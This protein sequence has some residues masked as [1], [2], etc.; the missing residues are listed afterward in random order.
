MSSH[1]PNPEIA[2][3]IQAALSVV[4]PIVSAYTYPLF[5]ADDR[6]RP[7]L[8][9]SSILLE[10]DGR[11]VLLTAAHAIHEISQAGSAVHLGAT[12]ITHLTSTFTRTSVDGQDPLDLAATLISEEFRQEQLMQALPMHRT[13]GSD[14]LS[15]PHMRCVHGY[16]ITK[17]KTTKRADETR[18]VFTRYGLTYAGA[19]HDLDVDFARHKKRNDTHLVMKYQ[20]ESRDDTGGQITPPHPKGI[21]GGGMWSIPDSFSPGIVFLEGI[22][23]EFRDSSLVFA[24]R[25]EHA[26]S[27]IRTSVI[28][29]AQ[30]HEQPPTTDA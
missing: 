29:A 24:T 22:A 17:N 30:T 1:D 3:H 19:S 14:F 20:R 15:K 2:A 10:V 12:S 4:H 13:K 26:I 28:P 9:A 16:P 11:L 5:A 25:I 27:F 18:K 23:I 7:D 8:Y 6:D 21:S